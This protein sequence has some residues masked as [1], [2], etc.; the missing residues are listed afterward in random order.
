MPIEAIVIY[1]TREQIVA[2]LISRYQA[3]VPDVHVEEDGNLRMFF[4]VLAEILEGVYLANQIQ[5]DNIFITTANLVELRR[6][7][8]QFGLQ[9]KTGVAATGTLRFTGAGG[10]FIEAGAIVGADVGGGDILYYVTTVDATIP[11]PGEPS[12]PTTVDSGVAS[13]PP[14]GTYEYG[15]TFLTAEGETLLGD[16]SVP[17]VT[18][19]ARRIDLS[20]LP[21]GGPGTTGRRLYR[22]RDG[23]GFKLVATLNTSDTT[24]QDTVA[25]G[26]LGAAPPTISTAER[27]SVPGAAEESG[28][29]YNAA[30]GTILELVEVP[31]GV[32]DVTNST[33]FSG[34]TDEEDMEAYRTRLLDH[35]RNPRTGSVAD[36][37]SW[38]EEV[39]G[40]DTATAFPNDNMGVATP[41]HVTV[42]VAGPNGAVPSVSVQT[43]VL[44][45]L[46]AEDIANISIHVTTFT[47]VPTN[48]TVTITLESGYALADVTASVQQAIM[49]YI[50]AI[51]VG[52]TV[53]MAGLID[54]VFG[55]PGVATVVLNSPVVD[56]TATA[57]QKRT[58]GTITVS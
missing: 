37:E 15:L 25:D 32:T 21:L 54:A 56:Q 16:T 36:L 52:G 51:P 26:A 39:E 53:Y 7:G 28:E 17:L 50:N 47:A 23:G 3:R 6:H 40:V 33:L 12:A 18:S 42:R 19:A 14:A 9:V 31:D 48:V 4:E 34:G 30:I 10:T 22:Q 55:L 43:A 5:R 2:D 58:P 27:V 20:N 57:T 46:Q 41:G 44:T 49:D 29:A 8:E 11:N 24:F 38:A 35:I 13:N 45:R 1:R